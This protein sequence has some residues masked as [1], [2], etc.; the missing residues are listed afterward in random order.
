MDLKLNNKKIKVLLE[1]KYVI[2][3]VDDTE[4][5]YATS[6]DQIKSKQ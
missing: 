4:G 3:E 1:G 6:F 5:R 2:E